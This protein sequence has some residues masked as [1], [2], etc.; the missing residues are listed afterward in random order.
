MGLVA[1]IV[2]STLLVAGGE[3]QYDRVQTWEGPTPSDLYH[4]AQMAES[5][6]LTW[7][8]MVDKGVPTEYQERWASCEIS[9]S[10]VDAAP[11][12]EP[13]QPAAYRF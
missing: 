4:C 2:V 5:L 3:T 9:L 12:P 11:E 1:S 7:R 6:T 13:A 8:A 10:E